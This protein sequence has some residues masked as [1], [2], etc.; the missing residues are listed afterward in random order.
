MLLH[1]TIIK[2]FTIVPLPG[3]LSILPSPSFKISYFMVT[4]LPYLPVRPVAPAPYTT[5]AEVT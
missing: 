3:R 5:A 4:A 1:I 2:M